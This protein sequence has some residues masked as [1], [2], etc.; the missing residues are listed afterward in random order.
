MPAARIELDR[1][2]LLVVDLQEKLMPLI[3]G[4]EAVTEAAVKLIR[5]CAALGAPILATEQYPEKLGATVEPVREAM[6]AGVAPAS[7]LKFSACIKPVRRFLAES[8]RTTVL[9]CGIESHVCV[10]QTALELQAAGYLPAVA[11][12][13]IG[14]RRGADHETAVRRLTQA[15]VVPVTAEMALMEMVHEAGTERFKAVLPVIR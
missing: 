12:D 2:A 13:A 3:A 5:G 7:K 1:T 6:G 15:G 8:G 11:V 9:I 10:L 4:G 14:A